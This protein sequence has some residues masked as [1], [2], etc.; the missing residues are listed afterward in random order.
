MKP[1]REFTPEEAKA[2]IRR[3]MGPPRREVVG[4]EKEQLLTVL[5]LIEP[6]GFSNNQRSITEDY[7]VGDVHYEVT[8][9]ENE[10]IV[11]EILNDE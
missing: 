8:Y 11:E 2:F 4:D 10:T 1:V 7:F 5:S 6:A 3:V 9:I